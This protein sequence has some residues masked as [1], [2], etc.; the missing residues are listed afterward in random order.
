MRDTAQHILYN[1]SLNAQESFVVRARLGFGY[2]S[3]R[4]L[5][6]IGKLMGGIS[7]LWIILMSVVLTYGA[8][9]PVVKIGR[10][11]G[12]FAKP[13]SSNIETQGDVSLPVYRGDN[14]NG[15]EFVQSLF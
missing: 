4:T 10:M 7:K 8:S 9:V 2:P 13:R 6:Q 5:D 15:I 12:Q 14:I 1:S 11:A 3:E